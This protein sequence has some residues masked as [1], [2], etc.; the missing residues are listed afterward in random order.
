M[1]QIW[2]LNSET[3]QPNFFSLVNMFLS[4]I[5]I[6]VELNTRKVFQQWKKYSYHKSGQYSSSCLLFKTTFPET[7]FRLCPK[8]EPIQFGP[9][10]CLFLRT[11][12]VFLLVSGDRFQ[13][14]LLGSI[15]KVPPK[16]A[17]RINSPEALRFE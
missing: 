12:M 16:D 14:Y 2:V 13:L 17:D 7:G 5:T 10:D 15:E 4:S 6:L 11:L 8:V 3:K 9:I 1:S